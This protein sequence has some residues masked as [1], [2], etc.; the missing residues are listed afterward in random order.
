METCEASIVELVARLAPRY[1]ASSAMAS[2]LLVLVPSSSIATVKFAR[3]GRSWGLASLPVLKT[4]RAE[5][6]G[7]EGRWL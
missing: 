5:V 6:I 4:S 7:S 2:A 1:A 3:P